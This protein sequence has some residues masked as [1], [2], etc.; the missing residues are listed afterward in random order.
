[1]A[2]VIALSVGVKPSLIAAQLG[3]SVEVLLNVYAKYLPAMMTLPK[4]R[5]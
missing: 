3:H 4:W 1:M 5:K 2:M